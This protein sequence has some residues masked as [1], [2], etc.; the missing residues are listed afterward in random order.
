MD[1][2]ATGTDFFTLSH[3]RY[4]T[5]QQNALRLQVGFAFAQHLAV[6]A[7]PTLNVQQAEGND[8]RRPRQVSFAEH[9]WTSGNTTVR[10]YPG[11]T[12]GLE[13]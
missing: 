4:S 7:G 10:M 11:F 13:F 3:S 9:V 6:V 8:D 1:L 2:A 12:A 5:R